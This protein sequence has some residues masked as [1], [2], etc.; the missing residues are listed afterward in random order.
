V[1]AQTFHTDTQFQIQLITPLHLACLAR[2]LELCQ[3]LVKHG[4]RTDLL[5]S[6]GKAPHDPANCGEDFSNYF[7]LEFCKC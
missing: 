3:Y 2:D 5:D 6:E 7:Q 4:A 1:N